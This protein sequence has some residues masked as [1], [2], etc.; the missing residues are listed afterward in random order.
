VEDEGSAASFP[1]I[2]GQRQGQLMQ[3]EPADTAAARDLA[4]TALVLGIAGYA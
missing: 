4:A 1:G 2:F 3:D